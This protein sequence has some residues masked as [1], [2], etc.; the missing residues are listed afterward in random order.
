MATPEA[1][2]TVAAVE[3]PAEPEMAAA[4]AAPQLDATTESP[5]SEALAEPDEPELAEAGP[6][7]DA[8][9]DQPAASAQ[10]LTGATSQAPSVESPAPDTAVT[11]PGA[12]AASPPPDASTE[13]QPGAIAAAPATTEAPAVS[14]PAETQVAAAPAVHVW[15]SSQKTREQ[16]ELG[17]Q[18]LKGAYPDLLGNLQ[19]TVREVD[20]GAEKGVWYRVYAGPMADRKE[21][22]ALCDRI[23]AQPPNSD[24]L[25]AAD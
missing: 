25:V 5:G 3:P 14:A 24:R 13:V 1:P 16:A 22:K 4:P 17:W 18:E 19:L 7:D 2:P 9:A 6:P 11:Q 23:K 20:L 10:T 15:L 8:I 12:I 21:A